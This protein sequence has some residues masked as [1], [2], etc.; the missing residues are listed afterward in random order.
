MQRIVVRR[1]KGENCTS[2]LMPKVL[3]KL[4]E[5]HDQSRRSRLVSE[6][7]QLFEVEDYTYIFVVNLETRSCCHQSQ[8]RKW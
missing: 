7:G 5:T 4:N 1:K 3:K 6:A 8:Q 2:V